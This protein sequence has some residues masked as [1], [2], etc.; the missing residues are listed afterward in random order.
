MESNPHISDCIL[1]T[2]AN[3]VSRKISRRSL[4]ATQEGVKNVSLEL[5]I[6]GTAEVESSLRNAPYK[7]IKTLLTGMSKTK[8]WGKILHRR[9]DC[10]TQ[11]TSFMDAFTSHALPFSQFFCPAAQFIQTRMGKIANEG[12]LTAKAREVTSGKVGNP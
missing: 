9:I 3:E 5:F 4:Q 1:S 2:V 7:F 8:V 11:L 10:W 6:A 12:R